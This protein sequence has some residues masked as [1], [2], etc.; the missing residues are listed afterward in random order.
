MNQSGSFLVTLLALVFLASIF[1]IG[2]L[3]LIL[4]AQKRVAIKSRLDICAV[5]LATSRET[6]LRDMAISNQYVTISVTAVYIARGLML[7][8]WTA[9]AAAI[10]AN[11]AKV[12]NRGM[13]AWQ[14]GKIL[15]QEAIE[16]FRMKCPAT[17]FSDELIGCA[18]SKPFIRPSIKRTSAFFPDIKNVYE[19][20]NQDL[21]FV[22]CTVLTDPLTYTTLDLRGDP[23]LTIDDYTDAYS[24]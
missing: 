13:T 12:A 20:R 24:K 19:W 4:S 18:L 17:P 11:V 1:F 16:K 15:A 23:T 14:D 8:P 2:S 5:S 21:G 7:V 22:T 10:G 6:F 9:P 3:K